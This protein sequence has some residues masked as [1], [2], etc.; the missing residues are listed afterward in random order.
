MNEGKEIFESLGKT[1]SM[2]FTHLYF[3]QRPRGGKHTFQKTEDMASKKLNLVVAACQNRG[4]GIN[5][6]LP[7]RLRYNTEVLF[8]KM[9]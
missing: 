7:W 2:K 6:Q 4:I 3:R 1:R 8:H 9:S 5:G